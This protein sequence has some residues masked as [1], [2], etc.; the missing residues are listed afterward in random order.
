MV[1]RIFSRAGIACFLLF[2]G[3]SF[4]GRL[5]A[6]VPRPPEKAGS[7]CFLQLSDTH[8]DPV[9]AGAPLPG[10]IRGGET[11]RWLGGVL[12]PSPAGFFLLRPSFLVVTGDLTEFGFSGRTA[13]LVERTFSSLG[14][15]WYAV[16][17]NHD[18]TWNPMAPFMRKRHGGRR[19]SFERFGCRFVVLPSS[20]I[21]EPLPTLDA[22]DLAW[23]RRDLAQ[24]GK[25]K[26]VFLFFHHPPASGEF[27]QPA[28]LAL[29][30]DAL[31]GYPVVLLCFGHGH[32]PVHLRLFG[33]LDCVEGGTTFRKR[34]GGDF[35]GVNVIS[36]RGGVLRS[37]YRF[38]DPA[39]GRKVLLEKRM[40]L[41]PPPLPPFRLLD[42]PPWG[43]AR[44]KALAVR[45]RAVGLGGGK[46]GRRLRVFL[47]GKA[48]GVSFRQVGKGTFSARM[49]LSG[50]EPGAHLLRVE[51]V[52]PG[53]RIRQ[54]ARV[55]YLDRGPV[56]VLWRRHLQAGIKAAP[57][58]LG[59]EV[60]V[61][62]L[63]GDVL[64]LSV[65][66]GRTLWKVRLP[67]EVVGGPARL[68]KGFVLGCGDGKVYAFGPRGGR[69]WI[70]DAGT[71]VYAPPL[72]AQ[73][74]VYV[75]DTAG[76]FHA[77]EGRTGKEAWAFHGAAYA[78]EAK[79]AVWGD[80]VLFGAWD[81][82]LYALERKTGR[83]RW[84]VLGP[85]A[86][87]GAARYYAPADCGPVPLGGGCF[88]CD[89]GYWLGRYDGRGKLVEIGRKGVSAL[90]A[91]PDRRFLNVRTLEEGLLR[92]DRRGR[93]AWSA[94]IPLGRIP[95]P[96]AE[97]GGRVFASSD[98]GKVFALEARSG[99]VLGAYRA[100]PGLYMMAPPA[101]GPGGTCLVAG[102]GGSVTALRY[103]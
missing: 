94:K 78:I 53:G 70:F 10:R 59:K 57:L 63:E 62:T 84:K 102:M 56:K 55:F 22:G 26:P 52:G 2:S 97:A 19:Y 7:F 33:W 38:V 83:L 67:A 42:P 64:G 82:R 96:P 79:A 87:R 8:L 91:S 99:K 39:K 85:R 11:F 37:V 71:P 89:R 27:A 14:L 43:K 1:T 76:V 17:G 28:Q 29:L 58:V 101:G 45:V 92:L 4:A 103:P 72:V 75:G 54:R 24:G 25:K 9:P 93:P 60:V 30:M 90:G 86:S 81:G 68:G 77:L 23:L 32:R 95:V 34:G 20:T 50:L 80:L 46:E 13:A 73:G 49:D 69:T 88:V 35:R 12:R 48:R 98:R 5:A 100:T 61:A 74:R 47:D 16:T 51:G 66:E 21:Q 40:S 41:S 44:G 6:Q 3:T 31:E 36:F 18:E 65:K 15:P